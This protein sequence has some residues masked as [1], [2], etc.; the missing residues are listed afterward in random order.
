V[1]ER[2]ALRLDAQLSFMR[3][4]KI[5]QIVNVPTAV[6]DLQQLQ[7]NHHQADRGS[8]AP[9]SLF[10][11]HS[12]ELSDDSQCC[13]LST[14]GRSICPEPGHCTSLRHRSVKMT[15]N[16]EVA[17]ACDRASPPVSEATDPFTVQ[18]MQDQSM[19]HAF[20]VILVFL[21][22]QYDI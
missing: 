14:R 3:R 18:I 12:P 15:S 8:F 20:G 11:K 13:P 4:L 21:R 6:F 17:R 19:H 1:R 7:H 5:F 2:F 16:D 22:Q 9:V 10:P